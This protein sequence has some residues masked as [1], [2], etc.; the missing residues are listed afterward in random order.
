MTAGVRYGRETIMAL[1]YRETA[2]TVK[3]RG[4]A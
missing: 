4:G 3:R 2:A 1:L